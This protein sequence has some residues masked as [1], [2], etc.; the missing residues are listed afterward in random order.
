MQIRANQVFGADTKRAQGMQLQ[1]IKTIIRESRRLVKIAPEMRLSIYNQALEAFF[2]GDF[3]LGKKLL[4]VVINGAM[5]YE[6]LATNTGIPSKSIH[7]MLSSKGNPS[8]TS[9]FLILNA[10]RKFDGFG[11]HV[12]VT[13]TPK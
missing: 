12:Q 7:R 6:I 8:S 2:K 3:A 4:R 1:E 10:V 13:Y 5:G 11:V 9:L